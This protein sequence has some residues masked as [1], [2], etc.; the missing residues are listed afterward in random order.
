MV[1]SPPGK[2]VVIITTKMAT[3]ISL[4]ISV[5]YMPVGNYTFTTTWEKLVTCSDSASENS[6]IMTV[7][8][9]S[10][11]HVT[12]IISGLDEGSTYNITVTVSNAAGN[13]T[14]DPITAMTMEAGNFGYYNILECD[15]T[16][17]SSSICCSS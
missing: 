13:A 10:T 11:E 2:P 7:A 17:L 15:Y 14:S 6:S 16:F 8:H 12:Q 5:D 1:A 9:A 3:T 4:N